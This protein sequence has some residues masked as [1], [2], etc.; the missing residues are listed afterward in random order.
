MTVFITNGKEIVENVHRLI[1]LKQLD[2]EIVFFI[3]PQKSQGIT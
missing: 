2:C 1:Y 3:P